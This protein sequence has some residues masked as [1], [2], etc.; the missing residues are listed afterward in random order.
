[1]SLLAF[2]L[3]FDSTVIIYRV[4]RLLRIVLIKFSLCDD[5]FKVGVLEVSLISVSTMD[6]RGRRISPHGSALIISG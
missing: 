2:T 4:L 1:M 6:L 3:P 5:E